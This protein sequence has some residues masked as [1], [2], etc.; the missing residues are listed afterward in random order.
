MKNFIF[1]LDGT[2]VDSIPVWENVASKFLISKGV[3][4]PKGIDDYF[5]TLALFQSSK[6]IA[7]NLLPNMTP[8]EI[9][10]DICN[11]VEDKYENEVPLKKGVF[12]FLNDSYN[13]GIHMAILT[14]SE[15]SYVEKA[16]KNL[17]IN[18]MF[19]E[20]ITCSSLGYAKDSYKVFDMAANKLK[21]DKS[22]T[23]IFDDSLYA[24]KSAKKAGFTVVGVYDKD[25]SNEEECRK[26]CDKYIYSFEEL[27][28]NDF[29]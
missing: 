13:M 14:A 15:Y 26:L 22:N 3:T 20:V 9:L 11:I 29:I 27:K 16:L 6:Y 12:K 7:E 18:H 21:F 10:R 28:I 2:L 8:D 1:D 4:P 23:I 17:K 25:C 5:K 24:M 19:K